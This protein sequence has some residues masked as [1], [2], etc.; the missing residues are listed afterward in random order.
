MLWIII[1]NNEGVRRVCKG[2]RK[3][4]GDGKNERLIRTH[5]L[6]TAKIEFA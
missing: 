6:E 5:N 1:G 3:E 4:R 2:Q